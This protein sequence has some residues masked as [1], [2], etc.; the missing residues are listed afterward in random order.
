MGSGVRH[1]AP[2]LVCA[3]SPRRRD[4][5]APGKAASRFPDRA[6]ERGQREFFCASGVLQ[7]A[8]HLPLFLNSQGN[9]K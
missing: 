8:G 4:A 5:F 7:R 2:D 3:R 9:W 6:L 1:R